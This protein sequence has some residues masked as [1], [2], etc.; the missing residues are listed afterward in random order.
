MTIL[1]CEALSFVRNQQPLLTDI[2]WQVEENQNWAILGLNG[3][4]KSLLLQ[5]ITGQLWPSSGKLTVLDTV[6]GQSSI[7]KLRQKIAWISPA[8]L[9]QFH[10]QETAE[11]IVVSG[12]FSSV[13]LYQTVTNEQFDHAK[14]LLHELG[15]KTIIGRSFQMLSQGQKQLVGIARALINRPKLLILDEPTNGLDLFAREDFLQRLHQLI[16][17][18]QIP[19]LV[20]VTHHTEEITTDFSHVLLLRDGKVM[21]QGQRDECLTTA[22]LSSFYQ[23]EVVILPYK[24]QRFLVYPV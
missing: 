5:L 2:N 16:A 4:G 22:H 1:S 14:Q 21:Y 6:F 10:G 19:N 15:L 12:Y 13:G 3:A 24:N 8:Y 17:Q 7:P 9:N 11:E 18:K 23:R 20:L